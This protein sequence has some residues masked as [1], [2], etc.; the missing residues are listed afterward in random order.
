M[1]KITK[2]A[3]GQVRV[4]TINDEPSLTQGQYK[5][6]TDVNKIMEKFRKTGSISHINNRTQGVYADLTNIPDYEGSL[7]SVLRAQKAFSDM[8]AKVRERFN[9]DPSKLIEFL[10]N[11]ANKKEGIDLG[12]LKQ[13]PV[14][15][16]PHPQ[17]PAQ[18]QAAAPQAA[19]T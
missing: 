9:N 6:M 3:N 17:D 14:A 8:P 11:P 16:V 4:Q 1:K 13:E 10:S 2:R 7:N 12:L 18:A 5:D 19:T 15:S